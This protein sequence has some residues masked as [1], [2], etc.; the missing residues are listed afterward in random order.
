V[1]GWVFIILSVFIGGLF[2]LVV[3]LVLRAQLKRPATGFKAMIGEEGR[4]QTE[5]TQE[6]GK[7]FV[8]GEIWNALSNRKIKQGT[9]VKV[10][11]VQGMSLIV[12][13]YQSEE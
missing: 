9:T 7:V 8:R 13:P 1:F 10:I 4:A 6:G 12:E 3:Y 5:V 2:L 11:D